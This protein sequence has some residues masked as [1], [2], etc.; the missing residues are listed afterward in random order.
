MAPETVKVLVVDD[1]RDSA[2]VL[3]Q[4][5]QLDGYAVLTA[6]GGAEA[7]PLVAREEPLCVLIDLNMPE[8][9]G[10]ELARHIRAQHG[11]ALVLV[12]V[13]G[14]SDSEA[15]RVAELAGIDHVL[16]KPID[17]ARLRQILPPIGSAA[18]LSR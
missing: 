5:L 4:L 16:P 18:D 1:D 10:A 12:A 2:V 11:T 14:V 3:Q 17:L 13:T 15:M 8:M 6:D 9:G 7:L